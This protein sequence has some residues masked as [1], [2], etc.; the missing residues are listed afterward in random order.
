MGVRDIFMDYIKPVGLQS[1]PAGFHHCLAGP[2]RWLGYP[3]SVASL[4]PAIGR[5]KT[6]S[7]HNRAITTRKFDVVIVGA[8]G[9]GMRAA[10]E[11]SRAGLNVACCPKSSPPARTP[12]PQ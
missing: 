8:G 3:G 9:S 2:L 1:G 11:L 5:Y 4:I 6:M 12:W 10:L 7:L